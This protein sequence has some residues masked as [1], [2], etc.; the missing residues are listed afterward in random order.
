MTINGTRHLIRTAE[1]P[2]PV[3]V[4]VTIGE[5][6]K[7]SGVSAKMIRY[8]ESIG[9]VTRA[10][11]SAAGYRHYTESDIKVLRFIRRARDLGFVSDEIAQLVKMWRGGVAPSSEVK[12]LAIKHVVALRERIAALEEAC[13]FIEQLAEHC[14]GNAEHECPILNGLEQP[15]ERPDLTLSSRDAGAR[16]RCEHHFH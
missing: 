2:T 9:L 6:A 5:A 14:P 1:T 10:V 8:Y 15:R 11:R 7:E 3:E 16:I 13:H 12:A 4:H